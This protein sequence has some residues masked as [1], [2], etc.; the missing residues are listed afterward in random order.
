MIQLSEIALK[1]R[2]RQERKV[3][4]RKKN[5]KKFQKNFKKWKKNGKN[6]EKSSKEEKFKKKEEIPRNSKKIHSK[7]IPKFTFSISLIGK[8]TKK[9]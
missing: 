3:R 9:V 5:F 4:G 8:I 1:S 7:M 6:W 2:S